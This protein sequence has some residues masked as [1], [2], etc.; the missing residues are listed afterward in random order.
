MG[1]KAALRHLCER[2]TFQE[3]CHKPVGKGQ[4]NSLAMWGGKILDSTCYYKEG[5][6]DEQ[7]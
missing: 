3:N 2:P 4:T 7:N 1:Q 5:L 6:P